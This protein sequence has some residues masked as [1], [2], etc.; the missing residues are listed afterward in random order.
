LSEADYKKVFEER[1]SEL[2]INHKHSSSAPNAACGYYG[3]IWKKTLYKFH[4][5]FYEF[6]FL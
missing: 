6:L 4:V 2:S 5:I 1:F 3:N